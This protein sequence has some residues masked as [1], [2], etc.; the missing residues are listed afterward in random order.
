MGL[1][2]AALASQSEALVAMFVVSIVVLWAVAT[3]V[4]TGGHL[5]HV[6]V[7]H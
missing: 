7:S 4:R 5:R 6:G 1:A 3:Y 2:I